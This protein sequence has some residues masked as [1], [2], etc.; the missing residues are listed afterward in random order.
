MSVSIRNMDVNILQVWNKKAGLDE[1][2][3][4]RVVEM[5]KDILQGIDIKTHFYKCKYSS[6]FFVTK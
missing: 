4:G 6:P 1:R 3:I 2:E 5:V